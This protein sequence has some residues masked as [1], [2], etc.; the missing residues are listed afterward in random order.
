MRDCISYKLKL[1]L[2]AKYTRLL[3]AKK[4]I[5]PRGIQRPEALAES[6]Q[7][8]TNEIED[9]CSH[10]Y[11]LIPARLPR[12]AAFLVS[13]RICEYLVSDSDFGT[14]DGQRLAALVD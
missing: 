7:Q 11:P 12:R 9:K 2:D 13:A 3:E 4:T 5:Q 6:K 10:Y 8:A 14:G 1:S